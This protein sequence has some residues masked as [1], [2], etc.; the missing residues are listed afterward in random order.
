[1]WEI[2]RSLRTE[3]CYAI[4]CLI[5]LSTV[6]VFI[7]N[8]SILRF[9]ELIIA[10]EILYSYIDI[11]FHKLTRNSFYNSVNTEFKKCLWICNNFLHL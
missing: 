9:L 5:I 1:M 10:A 4:C 3:I 7:V 8:Y 11:L 2:Y 6:I